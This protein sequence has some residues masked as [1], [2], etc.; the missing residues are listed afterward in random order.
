M[1]IEGP[2]LVFNGR[3]VRR[4]RK[5]IK[6]AGGNEGGGETTD[7]PLTLTWTSGTDDLTPVFS[8]SG[9][10]EE[11]D[12]ITLSIYSDAVLTTLVDSD[13]NPVDAAEQIAGTLSFPGIAALSWGTS[14]W[15]LA[16]LS[17]TG[18]SGTSNTETKTFPAAGGNLLLEGGTNQILMEGGTSLLLM[19][20]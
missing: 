4:V 17:G 16:T 19:E 1:I 14:Y 12:A 5:R 10:I 7:V 18:R 8:L 20:G 11:G 13:V 2:S 15:A 9:A 6:P 3:M